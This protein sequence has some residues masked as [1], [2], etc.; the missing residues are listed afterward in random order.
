MKLFG[1]TGVLDFGFHSK[2]FQFGTESTNTPQA[3]APQSNRQVVLVGFIRNATP[4][5]DGIARRDTNGKLDKRFGSGGA[6]TVNN[7]VNA[8]LIAIKGDILAIEATGNNG[9]VSALAN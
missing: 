5:F 2:E 1:E 4:K 7:T 3:L 8:P 9:I 6:L